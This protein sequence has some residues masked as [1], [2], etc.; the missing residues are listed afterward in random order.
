MKLFNS[1]RGGFYWHM[2]LV[3]SDWKTTLNPSQSATAGIYL[4]GE[5]CVVYETI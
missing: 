1:S 3:T 5:A 2:A 4:L